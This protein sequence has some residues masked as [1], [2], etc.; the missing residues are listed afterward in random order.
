MPLLH[1][2]MARALGGDCQ[3]VEL[4]RDTDGEI[5]DV[6]HL[7]DFAETLLD[8][9]AGLQR[10]QFAQC[11]LADAE[12]LAKESDKLASAW[13]GHVSPNPEG[14]DA[15]RNLGV[16]RSSVVE[17]DATDLRSIDRRSD[18]V[19]DRNRRDSEV[20]ENLFHR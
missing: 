4:S 3:S 15:L 10:D 14:I 13:R 9:L 17:C 6:D 12:L 1:H 19:T 5:A 11:L 20:C 2:A 7:L 16:D 8:D 18:R